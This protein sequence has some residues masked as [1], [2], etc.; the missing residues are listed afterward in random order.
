MK[1]HCDFLTELDMDVIGDTE[2]SRGAT[3]ITSGVLPLHVGWGT[4]AHY[5]EEESNMQGDKAPF[6]NWIK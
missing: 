3:S 1:S 4:L 2:Q 5:A 6:E